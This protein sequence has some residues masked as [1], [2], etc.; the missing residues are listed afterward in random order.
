[1]T[2][3]GATILGVEGARLTRAE[4]SFFASADPF[5][6]VLFSRNV[7]D[8]EQLLWLTTE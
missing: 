6:F 2:G 7:E 1:M 4:R 5:G 8:P 3:R